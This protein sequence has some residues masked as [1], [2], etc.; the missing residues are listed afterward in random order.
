MNPLF[1]LKNERVERGFSLIEA[2]IVLGVVGLVIGGIWVAA[3]SVSAQHRA[4]V[5][6]GDI[7]KIV[8]NTRSLIPLQS[9]PTT[10]TGIPIAA[11]LSVENIFPTDY[12]GSGNLVTSPGGV[13][14]G[15]SLSYSASLG[16][17][18]LVIIYGVARNNGSVFNSADCINLVHKFAGIYR[19]TADMK[20][21]QISTPGNSAYALLTPPIAPSSIECPSDVSVLSVYF[22]K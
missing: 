15:L 19:N 20:Y 7:S 21:I 6:A 18:F 16:P 22:G 14:M 11:I 1:I 4:S 2:A 5:L 3:A 13:R 8:A 10:N 12:T 9:Y 17:V